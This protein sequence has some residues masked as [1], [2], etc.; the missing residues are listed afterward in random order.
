MPKGFIAA[1]GTC[2]DGEVLRQ[3]LQDQGLDLAHVTV[4]TGCKDLQGAA[5]GRCAYGSGLL[6]LES[7]QASP[8]LVGRLGE[9]LLPGSPLEIRLPEGADAGEVSRNCLLAGF[10]S[11]GVTQQNGKVV[12]RKPQWETGAKSSIT[13]KSERASAPASKQQ[14]W[15]VVPEDDELLD[16]D[17]FLTEED[18][19]PPAAA[20]GGSVGSK[21]APVRK[22][23]KNCTCGRA[24]A[25]AKGV[26]V[27]LT[28]EMLDNPQ[29]ACGS[30]GLGDG[31]RCATCPYRGLP[32]FEMGKKIKLTSD[33]LVADA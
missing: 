23:C 30:C 12:V 4:M 15:S 10:I 24:E 11:R 18:L 17:E 29:S 14:V 27:E 28:Q 22:A 20:G 16:E 19:K 25:E 2:L 7:P 8:A 21:D 3:L 32:A 6:L 13:L 33:F 9:A 31:F 26:K 5:V 1:E